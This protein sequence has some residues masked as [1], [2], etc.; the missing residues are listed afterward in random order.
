MTT[1]PLV[2]TIRPSANSNI[3][4]V[5]VRHGPGTHFSIAFSTQ[6]QQT[7][8]TVLE[9]QMDAEQRHFGGKIFQWF[10]LTFPDQ[11]VGWVRDDLV[12]IQG[13]GTRFGYEIL[14]QPTFAFELN[15]GDATT[16][17]SQREPD[18]IPAEPTPT[19]TSNLDRVIAAAFNITAAFEGSGYASYQNTDRGIVSYGRFQFTLQSSNLFAVV[20]RYIEKSNSA[21]AQALQNEYLARIRSHDEMLRADRRLQDLLIQ[22]A[23]EDVMRE[24]QNEIAFERFWSVVYNLSV[25]PRNIRFPLT[26]AMCF[27]IGI[28]HGPRHALFT[29][30]ETALGIIARSRLG[31]NGILETIFAQRV[32]EIR[33]DILYRI[34]DRDNVPGVKRRADFWLEIIGTGDWNLQG[35]DGG[36]VAVFGKRV[37]IR[38]P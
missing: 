1:Q 19:P 4:E 15:R 36:L 31:E 35:D 28:Q 8:L 11:R 32:A 20:E 18:P 26:Q 9:V 12:D 13:D 16:P 17:S 24:A 37:Q 21:I 14:T 10:K 33:R 22:A 29:Q 6:V 27:D 5:N 25:V 30:A 3:R 2:A 7:G 38:N 23:S 34:A